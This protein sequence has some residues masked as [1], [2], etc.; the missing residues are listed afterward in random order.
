[1]N[2][3]N[4]LQIQTPKN[5]WIELLRLNPIDPNEIFFEP[6]A[7]EKSLLD[8]IDTNKKYWNEIEENKDVFDF[9]EKTAVTV[10][11]CQ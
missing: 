11:K 2:T 10:L 6:F 3:L 8:L 9:K 7:G 1:M 4:Y 5:V